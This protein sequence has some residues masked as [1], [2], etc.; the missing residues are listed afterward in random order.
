MSKRWRIHQTGVFM[1]L[2]FEF[3]WCLNVS[4]VVVWEGEESGSSVLLGVLYRFSLA[5]LRHFKSD[6]SMRP[7]RSLTFWA[8]SVLLA[9]AIFPLLRLLTSFPSLKRFLLPALGVVAVCALPFGFWAVRGVLPGS[10][11]EGLL[12]FF[13]TI[14]AIVCVILY[15]LRSRQLP[16]FLGAFALMLHF[17][18]WGFACHFFT[19]L[20]DA[21]RSS[22]PFATFFWWLP[23]NLILSI[24]GFVSCATWAV[25]ARV[26]LHKSGSQVAKSPA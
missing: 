14:G 13:E 1:R 19:G 8:M 11:W 25:Y 3:L 17:C 23:L 21:F 7:E 24:L 4:A 10:T 18:I 5:L 15:A 6:I 12:L 9:V 26:G 20:V 2:I 22:G 16:R